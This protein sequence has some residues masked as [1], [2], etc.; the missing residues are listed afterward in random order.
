MSFKKYNHSNTVLLI[1]FQF[2]KTILSQ[3][4]V[5]P[6]PIYY[7]P[8]I[9]HKDGLFQL[10]TLP[11]VV[12]IADKYESFV[13]QDEINKCQIINPGSFST[14]GYEFIVY[15]PKNQAVEQSSCP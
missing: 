3:R 12:I 1:L 10:N 8:K 9:L 15:Y 7:S 4:H 11:D 14:S 2:C 5:S 6:L 13:Y